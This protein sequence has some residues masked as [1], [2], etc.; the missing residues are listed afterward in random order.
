MRKLQSIAMI[1][2]VGSLIVGCGENSTVMMST[3]TWYEGTERKTITVKTSQVEEFSG[4]NA[5]RITLDD[6][7]TLTIAGNYTIKRYKM[8]K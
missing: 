2:V 6:R 4:K 1:A 8:E 7:S 5:V 3:V